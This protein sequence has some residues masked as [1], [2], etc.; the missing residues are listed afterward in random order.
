MD[1]ITNEKNEQ[2]TFIGCSFARNDL[3]RVELYIDAGN[4]LKNQFV[5]SG[6]KDKK[7]M[8]EASIA[9]P[10]KWESLDNRR[11]SRIAAY[12]PGAITDSDEQLGT[13]CNW[14]VKTVIQF[15]KTF[16]DELRPEIINLEMIAR[17]IADS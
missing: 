9:T 13:L 8:I 16:Q 2:I 15:Y 7:D 6:L 14:A 17:E 11:A 3:F 1:F 4:H 10:I 5:F 12:H